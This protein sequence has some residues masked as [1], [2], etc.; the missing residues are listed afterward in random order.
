MLRI[1]IACI[2]L[3]A[4][5]ECL[6]LSQKTPKSEVLRSCEADIYLICGRRK[7]SNF[8][9]FAVDVK[10]LIFVS[11]WYYNTQNLEFLSIMP[12]CYNKSAYTNP[13]IFEILRF[14]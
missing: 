12:K 11:F 10:P 1:I 4:K 8:G 14:I 9:V 3:Y 6:R 2:G 5:S 7:T 13:P